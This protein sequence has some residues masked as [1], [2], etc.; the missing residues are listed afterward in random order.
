MKQFILAGNKA[1]TTQTTLDKVEEG[2]VGFFYNNAGQLAVSANGTGL[3]NE[4]M[5]VLGKPS[6]QGGPV[7]IPIHSNDFSFVKGTYSAATVYSA[8][9]TVGAANKVGDYTVIVVKKGVK[10]NERCK[11][12]ADIHITDIS[13]TANDLAAKIAKAINDNSESSGVKAEVA[14][15][16][17]TV[18]ALNKGVDYELIMADNLTGLTVTTTSQG[19]PGY[20]DAE[21]I[22]KLANAAAAD[23][24]IEYTYMDDIR[25]LYPKYPINP[26]EVP[27][28]ADAGFTI[29]TL[30]FAEPRNTKTTDEAVKQIVQVAFPTGAAAI[31]TFE[32]V[33]TA[34]VN[35]GPIE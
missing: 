4:F 31:T 9:F 6:N 26:L 33:C 27:N 2:A 12:T 24:G 11:W 13:T 3:K 25:Y 5:L 17:V 1:Y 32:T 15:A 10:F 23:A 19:L 16:K 14:S 34:I 8:N 22:K 20:G 35:G 21:Y 18:T 28:S 29:F 7:V 30:K